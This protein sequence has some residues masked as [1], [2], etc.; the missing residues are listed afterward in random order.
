MSIGVDFLFHFSCNSHELLEAKI[1]NLPEGSPPAA[2]YHWLLLDRASD[3]FT[4]LKFR[5]M[6]SK[7]GRQQR[8]FEQGDLSFDARQARLGLHEGQLQLDLEPRPVE[9]MPAEL[10]NKVRALLQN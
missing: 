2:V 9:D 10:Q 3:E 4:R 8:T 5:A 6:A 7:D 1:N